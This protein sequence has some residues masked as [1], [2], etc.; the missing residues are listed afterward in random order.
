MFY[1]KM[2]S[3]RVA[4]NF[5]TI[6][7]DGAVQ[8]AF[9]HFSFFNLSSQIQRICSLLS[10]HQPRE[11]AACPRSECTRVHTSRTSLQAS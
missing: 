11:L 7:T 5:M 6:M 9:M 1:L 4:Y 10:V 2:W 8:K 3:A